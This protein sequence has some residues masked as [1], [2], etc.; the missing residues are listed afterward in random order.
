MNKW[1]LSI[2]TNHSNPLVIGVLYG[3]RNNRPY[4]KCFLDILCK[5]NVELWL[6]NQQIRGNIDGIN[7][8]ISTRVEYKC[9][10]KTTTQLFINNRSFSNEDIYGQAV[11]YNDAALHGIDIGL[12]L[13]RKRHNSDNVSGLVIN[14]VD[15]LRPQTRFLHWLSRGVPTLYYPTKAYKELA[16]KYNYGHSV[17]MELS[18]ITAKDILKAVKLLQSYKRR[19]SLSIEG[20]AIA[21]NYKTQNIASDLISIIQD[22]QMKSNRTSS[23]KYISKQITH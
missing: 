14:N 11:Y 19:Q 17:D 15:M 10:G 12:L 5:L 4:V 21:E 7:Q 16:A 22:V 20:L 2:P 6:I 3:N 23:R 18:V 9:K 8:T 13:P 1:G